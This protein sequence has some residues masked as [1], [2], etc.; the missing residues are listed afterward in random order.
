MFA[1]KCFSAGRAVRSPVN[2]RQSASASWTEH[3]PHSPSDLAE[4]SATSQVCDTSTTQHSPWVRHLRGAINP[5]ASTNRDA[6]T[7]NT[8]AAIPNKHQAVGSTFEQ[9]REIGA[10]GLLASSQLQPGPCSQSADDVTGC[11]PEESDSRCASSSLSSNSSSNSTNAELPAAV[12][13]HDG[14]YQ[15]CLCHPQ[16]SLELDQE[17]VLSE[18]QAGPQ[19]QTATCSAPASSINTNTASAGDTASPGNSSSAAATGKLANMGT[20]QKSDGSPSD[21]GVNMPV[22]CQCHPAVSSQ[23]IS[24]QEDVLHTAQDQALPCS[25]KA[26]SP[27]CDHD[28]D[29]CLPG[30]D[31]C[32][33]CP[34]FSAVLGACIDLEGAA[35]ICNQTCKVLCRM[36]AQRFGIPLGTAVTCICTVQNIV[37]C[38]SAP[39]SRIQYAVSVTA[40]HTLHPHRLLLAEHQSIMQHQVACIRSIAQLQP[41][42]PPECCRIH[43]PCT[44][45]HFVDGLLLKCRHN[46]LLCCCACCKKHQ[47]VRSSGAASWIHYQPGRVQWPWQPDIKGI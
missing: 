43:Q 28:S 15:H 8:C 36:P 39:L 42:L 13:V 6:A 37:S 9:Q 19:L 46:Q 47:H 24:L 30:T 32:D 20:E 40:L 31:S 5:A 45:K 16:L 17:I 18:Q 11:E 41:V 25:S 22:G 29:G 4:Q 44:C 14:D 27:Q 7:V 1:D 2:S 10:S 33:E 23:P 38:P 3:L 35:R 26:T 21:D 34:C 12:Q